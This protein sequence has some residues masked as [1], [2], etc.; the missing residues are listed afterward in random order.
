MKINIAKFRVSPDKKVKL[1]KWPTMVE[2]YY[3]SKEEYRKL[4]E[5]QV[6]E[7]SSLQH[8]HYAPGHH[9][10][11]LIF[12]GMEPNG[13][14][15]PR[16]TINPDLRL[17]DRSSSWVYIHHQRGFSPKDR[18]QAE[19]LLQLHREMEVVENAVVRFVLQNNI[20]CSRGENKAS[21]GIDFLAGRSNLIVLP[22]K[23]P[24]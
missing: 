16:C 11:L 5:N 12:Q 22:V 14:Q 3:E 10:L 6:N 2:P 18:R 4:L 1:H 20:Q 15:L 24:P 13:F 23:F 21:H 9:A 7:L 17:Y 19:G 8:L